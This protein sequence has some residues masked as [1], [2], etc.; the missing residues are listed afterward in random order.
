MVLMHWKGHWYGKYSSAT[1]VHT[2]CI[3]ALCMYLKMGLLIF[4]FCL[5]YQSQKCADI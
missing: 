1:L 3:S 2:G 4:M 5:D